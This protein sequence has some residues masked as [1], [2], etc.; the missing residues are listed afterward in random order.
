MKFKAKHLMN[1]CCVA[2]GAGVIITATSWPFKTAFFPSLV[3]IFLFFGGM[4][5]LL[6]DVFGS[7]EAGAKQGPVDF[8][9]S[10]DIDPA[11]ATR[12]TLLAFGWVL[13]FFLLILL[14]GFTLSV[15]LLV[16]LFLKIQAREKWGISLFLTGS[17]LVFFF[18]LFVWLLN[19]PFSEGWILEGLKMLW[20]AK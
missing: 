15:P 4:A 2:I 20:A 11:V 18:G 12:R 13:G 9:L 19:I 17:S 10:D 5:D 16:F 8:Q 14:F 1:L 6:L 3:G 7:K